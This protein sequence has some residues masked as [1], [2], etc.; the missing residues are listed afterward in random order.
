M[1]NDV[2]A[3]HAGQP[4]MVVVCILGRENGGAVLSLK[5]RPGTSILRS[6]VATVNPRKQAVNH[7]RST[8]LRIERLAHIAP[9]HRDSAFFVELAVEAV[10][11][12]T[13]PA[14]VVIKLVANATCA[15]EYFINVT[16]LVAQCR[17][18]FF[19]QIIRRQAGQGEVGRVRDPADHHI[20]VS[21]REH[22]LQAAKDD[23][24]DGERLRLV[25]SERL[26]A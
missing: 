13:T 24:L 23:V 22:A 1:T 20:H 12:G 15:L 14:R 16:T 17:G 8:L 2:L 21:L 9:R 26:E 19:D 18:D 7:H 6:C 4:P 5:P 3:L 25:D 11:D 10:L